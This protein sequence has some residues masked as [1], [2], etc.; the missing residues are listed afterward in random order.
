MRYLAVA[1]IWLALVIIGIV[2]RG[3]VPE[4]P[5]AVRDLDVNHL[6]Q[7][8]DFKADETTPRYMV[9]RVA[10]GQAVP[11][12]AISSQPL[13]P[14]RVLALTFPVPAARV[15]DG[16]VNAN[17]EL[18]LCKGA[19]ELANGLRVLTV[20]CSARQDDDCITLVA[21]PGDKAKAV[22][23]ALGPDMKAVTTDKCG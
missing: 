3:P 20:V 13:L 2:G 4:L 17:T 19:S 14:P 11:P 7:P 15:R 8:G 18:R 12:D 1:L 6:L 9:K 5:A 16:S 21:V 22:A 23:D 10:K